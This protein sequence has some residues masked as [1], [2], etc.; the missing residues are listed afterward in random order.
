MLLKE[1]SPPGKEAGGDNTESHILQEGQN[2]SMHC[3]EGERNAEKD[4]CLES[5]FL[6]ANQLFEQNLGGVK[7]SMNHFPGCQKA[8]RGAVTW[9]STLHRGYVGW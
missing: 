3:Q 8:S 2:C 1:V 5:C 9:G 7:D 6:R 4:L